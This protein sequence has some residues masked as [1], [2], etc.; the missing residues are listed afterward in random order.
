MQEKNPPPPR[1]KSREGDS[2]TMS[3]SDKNRVSGQANNPATKLDEKINSSEPQQ[4]LPAE[5]LTCGEHHTSSGKYWAFTGVQFPGSR[6]TL[7]T[8]IPTLHLP[9]SEGNL[10]R[11]INDKANYVHEKHSQHQIDVYPRA[12]IRH[13]NVRSSLQ[14]QQQAPPTSCV[15]RAYGSPTDLLPSRTCLG[16]TIFSSEGYR[17]PTRVLRITRNNRIDH[18]RHTAH[19]PHPSPRSPDCPPCTP[20]QNVL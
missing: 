14:C 6:A 1:R 13:H 4:A 7:T 9:I 17:D 18:C 5:H 11:Q 3:V 2:P 16:E 19:A 12:R 8:L 10:T 15:P 20:S